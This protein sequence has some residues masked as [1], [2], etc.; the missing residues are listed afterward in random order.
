MFFSND[1]LIDKTHKAALVQFFDS[2]GRIL[3]QAKVRAD[4]IETEEDE[5][6]VHVFIDRGLG[7]IY[8]NCDA[9]YGTEHM[10]EVIR[11]L[12]SDGGLGKLGRYPNHVRMTERA[13]VAA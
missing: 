2:Y 11:W 12:V 3:S 9:V 1:T 5:E 7:T 13:G 4:K 8:A 6:A 10:N